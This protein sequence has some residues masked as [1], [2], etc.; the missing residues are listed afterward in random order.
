[1]VPIR[2]PLLPSGV[3]ALNPEP[4]I[5]GKLTL[6]FPKPRPNH[7]NRLPFPQFGA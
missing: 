6:V 2:R 3:V 7:E 1:M 4:T 5:Y